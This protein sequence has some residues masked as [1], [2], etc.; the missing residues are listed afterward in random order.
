MVDLSSELEN[1]RTEWKSKLDA[2][3]KGEGTYESFDA[4]YYKYRFV[5]HVH[6]GLEYAY[7]GLPYKR[8]D[9]GE[10]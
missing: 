6:F 10:V 9:T 1:L 4:S 8:Y 3:A 2:W 7:A 5:W